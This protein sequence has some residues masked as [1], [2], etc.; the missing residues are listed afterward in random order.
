VERA[1]TH[2]RGA[3]TEAGL[4]AAPAALSPAIDAVV[5]L[6]AANSDVIGERAAMSHVGRFQLKTPIG[7]GGLGTVFDAWDPLLSREVAIKTVQFGLKRMSSRIALDRLVLHEARAAAQLNHRHIATVYEAGLSAH[8]V[9][10]AMERLRGRDLRQA[11]ADGWRPAMAEALKITR[12]VADALAYAHARGVIH[13]DIKPSN[14][15][16]TRGGR[17][18]LLDF[19]IARAVN[20]QVV[21]ELDGLTLGSPHYMAPEQLSG[22]HVDVRS[23]IY[24]LGVVLYELLCGRRAFPGQSLES[25]REAVN[26]GRCESLA[27]L[28]PDLPAR[29]VDLV[30]RTMSLDPQR[31]PPSAQALSEALRRLGEREFGGP[32][33]GESAAMGA[34]AGKRRWVWP[35]SLPGSGLG[36][37][38]LGLGLL[39]MLRSTAPD[40]SRGHRPPLADVPEQLSAPDVGARPVAPLRE[41]D[42]NGKPAREGQQA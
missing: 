34:A 29:L 8:G 33:A 21:P 37:L 20:A 18:K 26:A 35:W 15:F 24:S 14:I 22:R 2:S 9:Y 5:A 10:L 11:L 39:G 40:D 7:D 1:N 28:R 27:T 31:R 6:D 17:P 4:A 3:N 38:A 23:D 12:R 19:G 30:Q 25:L 42:I 16:L 13:G 36:L 32:G 41:A